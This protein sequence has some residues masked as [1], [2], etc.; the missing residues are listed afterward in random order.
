M[1]VTWTRKVTQKFP[2]VVGIVRLIKLAFFAIGKLLPNGRQTVPTPAL[3]L[4]AQYIPPPMAEEKV[5]YLNTRYL[6]PDTY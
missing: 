3:I 2:P 4:L 6:I 5:S 1:A